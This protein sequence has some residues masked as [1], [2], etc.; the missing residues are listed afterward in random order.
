[1]QQNKRK[2]ASW[3][4]LKQYEPWDPSKIRQ[5]TEIQWHMRYNG[6]ILYR[7]H[8][9]LVQELSAVKNANIIT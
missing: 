7:M 8:H 4:I 6:Y 2:Q 1:M 3:G 9:S 5:A